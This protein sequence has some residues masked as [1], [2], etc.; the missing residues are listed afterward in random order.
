VSLKKASF[1]KRCTCWDR[2]S[3]ESPEGYAVD[4][5]YPTFSTC[6]R[7]PSSACAK[8][9]CAGSSEGGSGTADAARRCH[10]RAS[11]RL[12]RAPGKAIRRLAWRLVGARPRGTLCHKPCTVSGGGKSEISKSIA[13]AI[14]EG[15]VFVN[16]F[17]HDIEQVAEILKKDFSGIYK[18]PP[19]R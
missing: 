11:Q 9:R 10:L 18:Q 6:R 13:N 15:P 2:W 14:L 3:S 4:R 5:R 12:P 1:A 19:A 8:A 17:H 7:I 16:D